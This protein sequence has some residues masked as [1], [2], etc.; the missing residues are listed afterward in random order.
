[1]PHVRPLLLPYPVTQASHV[2]H[3]NV[4]ALFLTRGLSQPS[5]V[6]VYRHM[7]W[8][9]H[10]VVNNYLQ[11]L[12]LEYIA[13]TFSYIVGLGTA[14]CSGLLCRTGVNLYCDTSDTVPSCKCYLPW[15]LNTATLA[16]DC[17]NVLYHLSGSSCRK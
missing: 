2:L 10:R 15:T 9:A 17:S 8:L 5:H 12:K 1:M 6:T 4:L 14:P 13:N 16:C 7:Q 3:L 11:H